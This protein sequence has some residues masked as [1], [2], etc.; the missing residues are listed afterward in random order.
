MISIELKFWDVPTLFAHLESKKL[1][2]TSF[3]NV[4]KCVKV[5]I[6]CIKEVIKHTVMD[7]VI[8]ILSKA[9]TLTGFVQCT[10]CTEH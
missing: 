8:P 2:P 7:G 6:V 1:K 10:V 5:Y 4:K 9:T 3:D